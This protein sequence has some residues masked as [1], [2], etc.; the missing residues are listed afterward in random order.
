MQPDLFEVLM[1]LAAP[2]E[3]KWELLSVGLIGMKFKP[4]YLSAVEVCCGSVSLSSTSELCYYLLP[5]L[6]SLI[7]S[8]NCR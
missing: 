5:C 1:I 4:S 2:A 8:F 3:I 6:S 7:S